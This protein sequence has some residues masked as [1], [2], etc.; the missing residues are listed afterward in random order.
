MHW[1]PKHL[2]RDQ[3]VQFKIELLFC[4]GLSLH[5]LLKISLAHH[6]GCLLSGRDTNDV[7]TGVDNSFEL[8]LFLEIKIRELKA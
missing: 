4:I 3:I 1:P 6:T 5:T 7:S 8:N 2:G